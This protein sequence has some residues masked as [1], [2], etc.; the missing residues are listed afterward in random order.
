MSLY[1]THH[2]HIQAF[3]VIVVMAKFIICHFFL[4]YYNELY[5]KYN[6][7]F[8]TSKR[9]IKF[10]YDYNYNIQN[11]DKCDET[12]RYNDNTRYC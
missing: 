6:L 2:K 1:E 5:N 4:L 10:F 8:K 12:I 9:I 11:T 3:C 7:L